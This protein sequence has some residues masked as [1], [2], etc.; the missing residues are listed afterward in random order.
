MARANATEGRPRAGGTGFAGLV[1][2]LISGLATSGPVGATNPV[3]P[4]GEMPARFTGSGRM[5]S[6]GTGSGSTGSGRMGSGGTGSGSTG[7]G[8]TAWTRVEAA[9]GRS[10]VARA[11]ALSTT[12]HLAVAD[13]RGVRWL[14]PVEGGFVE[15][16]WS[17]LP[18]VTALAFLG[19]DPTSLFVGS[20]DGLR[21][22][23]LAR[24]P[25]RR[26][27]RG[28]G[29]GER[30]TDLAVVAGGLVVATTGGAHWS[31]SGKRFGL[32]PSA[33]VATPVRLVAGACLSFD[34]QA[35]ACDRVEIWLYGAAGLERLSGFITEHGLVETE[36]ERVSLPRPRSGE[37]EAVDLVLD[38]R[39]G[40]VILLY[41]D[42]IA[43]RPRKHG[44]GSASAWALHRPVLAAGARMLRL[45]PRRGRLLV[46][47]DRGIFE[48]TSLQGP[49]RHVRGD[50][51]QQSCSE[52]VM[53][54]GAGVAALCRS[55]VYLEREPGPF[56]SAAAFLPSPR[57]ESV[58]GQEA[59]P[60][61]R[62]PPDPPVSLL[63]RRAL[64]QAGLGPD[65]G[66]RLRAG[67]HER[68]FW[69]EVALRVEGDFDRGDRNFADQSFVSGGYRHLFDRTR[70]RDTGFEASLHL[71][72]SLGEIAFPSAAV[73]LSREL[74]QV[75]RLRDDVTDEIHQLYFERQRL[76]ARLAAGVG[77]SAQQ[78]E[79][80]LT[81]ARELDAG[82]DA[83]SGGWLRRWRRESLGSY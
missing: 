81:R 13:D 23:E 38:E 15:A 60:R 10:E 40:R 82:L 46:A 54:E 25:A 66:A 45:L 50:F 20:V 32:I 64:E 67:L 73:D 80:L 22:W 76:R 69:P 12:D 68:G 3:D 79:S 35:A 55:G 7:S 14:R 26:V 59:E 5:G 27:L 17:G 18:A 4:V 53:A 34:A 58:Q 83:W 44:Q 19:S 1:A 16:A 70:A 37:V 30:V 57:P 42:A 43:S 48:G 74:R 72:W 62:L 39:A 75:L 11:L 2:V 78:A 61:F 56:G 47:S 63:R 41:P 33:G 65:W 31:S 77:L 9:L 6:G 71:E 52:L 8:S 21:R 29:G 36:R 51:A 28:P 24:E 49:F